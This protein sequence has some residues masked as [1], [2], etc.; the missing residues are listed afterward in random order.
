MTRSFIVKF[1]LVVIALAALATVAIGTIAVPAIWMM[2]GPEVEAAP[3]VEI[4][5]IPVAPVVEIVE[6][7]VKEVVAPR[8]AR[9]V[10][11][12]EIVQASDTT[13]DDFSGAA[14]E[15]VEAAQPTEVQKLEEFALQMN[16]DYFKGIGDRGQA[17]E[18]RQMQRE[19]SKE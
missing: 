13:V 2:S 17:R 4:V 11:T 18:C 12:K 8:P 5:T 14:T 1:A 19:L 7:E 16:C 6:I 10:S 15:I 9:K 3:A